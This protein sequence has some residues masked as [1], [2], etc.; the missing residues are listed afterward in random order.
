[1]SEA[2]G[3]DDIIQR[4]FALLLVRFLTLEDRSAASVRFVSV[5][6]VARVASSSPSGSR[7]GAFLVDLGV[8][9]HYLQTDLEALNFVNLYNIPG[10]HCTAPAIQKRV[11]I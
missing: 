4:C 2:D 8:R 1:M 10:K 9:E 6:G 7:A 11:A 5:I 3:V